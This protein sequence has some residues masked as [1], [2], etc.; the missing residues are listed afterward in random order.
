MR[1]TR[2]FSCQFDVDCGSRGDPVWSDSFAAQPW[3]LLLLG[4][5]ARF[6]SEG[7]WARQGSNLQPDRY[8]GEDNTRL[9]FACLVKPHCADNGSP[10][11]VQL[12]PSKTAIRSVLNGV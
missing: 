9:C 12:A 8:E 10:D 5:L 4:S 11:N 3:C 1:E 7:W 6:A 2:T